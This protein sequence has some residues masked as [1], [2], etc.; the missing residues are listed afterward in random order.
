MGMECFEQKSNADLEQEIRDRVRILEDYYWDLIGH[1]E[2]QM[3]KIIKQL[4]NIEKE[5]N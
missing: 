1:D 3:R 4:K 5:L 2:K